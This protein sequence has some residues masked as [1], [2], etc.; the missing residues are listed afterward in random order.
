MNDSVVSI[1]KEFK[2]AS[3]NAKRYEGFLLGKVVAP[4]PDI[5]I[6]L[7]E[8]V[9][10]DK[11]NLILAAN[12]VDDYTKNYEMVGTNPLQKG[13]IKFTDKLKNGEIL[14]LI[15]S[16]NDNMYIVIDR[17]VMI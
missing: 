13:R 14:I 15:P 7:S 1:A 6:Q 12:L 2:N 16:D 3:K 11:S 8:E 4:L 10:L 5:K 9:S 17:A